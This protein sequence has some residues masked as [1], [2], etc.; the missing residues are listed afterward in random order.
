[1]I[2]QTIM[3]NSCNGWRLRSHEWAVVGPE[4]TRSHYS[5]PLLLSSPRS[6]CLLRGRLTEAW[7]ER[8]KVTLEVQSTWGLGSV[9]EK[10]L[11]TQHLTPSPL[12]WVLANH[13]LRPTTAKQGTTPCARSV[14]G[15]FWRL[16]YS[17]QELC[18]LWWS[19]LYPWWRTCPCLPTPFSSCS[20]LCPCFFGKL[21]FSLSLSRYFP[22]SVWL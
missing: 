21:F 1:M 12:G 11:E 10:F 6:S 17:G 8:E 14:P 16:H 9:E 7:N 20:F 13:S 18:E 19:Q 4:L 3:G 15:P 22:S 5:R 2:T